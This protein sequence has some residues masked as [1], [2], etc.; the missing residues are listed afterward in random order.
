MSKNGSHQR[1]GSIAVETAP[2]AA[3]LTAHDVGS[4]AVSE[5]VL[6]QSTSGE[7]LWCTSAACHLL[8]LSTEELVG[9]TWA[10]LDREL[11]QPD[12]TAVPEDQYPWTQTS[13]T[14]APVTESVMGITRVDG[15]TLWLSIDSKLTLSNDQ[16]V[17]ITL[18]LDVSS[19]LNRRAELNEA[20]RQIAQ[21]LPQTKLPSHDR[22]EF[23]SKTRARRTCDIIARHFCGAHLLSAGR[24]AFFL[25]SIKSQQ[26]DAAGVNSFARNT[27]R[28]AGALLHDPHEVLF[29]M[30]D[31][32]E[33]EWPESSIE[34]IFGYID[35]DASSDFAEI[36]VACGGLPMPTIITK[37]GFSRLDRADSTIDDGPDREQFT[38]S[39]KMLA[40][41]RLV[42][43]TVRGFVGLALESQIRDH[44]TSL[45][46]LAP[47]GEVLDRAHR[48]A[49]ESEPESDRDVSVLVVAFN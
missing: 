17:I 22:V 48:I 21:S 40:G 23:A 25:G 16:P 46:A 38:D 44:R 29:H 26:T 24:Y 36:R 7:I 43:C 34:A 45:N 13:L 30:Q 27:L 49:T 11:V 18:L 33:G 3:P 31:A 6:I 47:I 15:T 10:E 12:G 39:I 14:G 37:T 19:E 35:I 32:I 28:S 4:D 20:M 1:T 2:I 5:G 42:L 41:D 8:H 9:R